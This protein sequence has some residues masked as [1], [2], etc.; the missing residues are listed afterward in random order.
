VALPAKVVEGQFNLPKLRSFA[1][2]WSTEDDHYL[3]M[4]DTLGA[5]T[6]LGHF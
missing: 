1:G 3:W 4:P 5:S 2:M 6:T